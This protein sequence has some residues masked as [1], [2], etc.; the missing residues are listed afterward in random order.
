MKISVIIPVYNVQYYLERCLNSIVNQTYTNLEIILIDDGSTDKSGEICDSYAKID[1]RITVVHKKNEG[2][3]IARNVALDMMTG[4]YISF[5]DSDDFLDLE[6][7]EKMIKLMKDNNVKLAVCSY[8]SFYSE[9]EIQNFNN[10]NTECSI[11]PKIELLKG[12]WVRNPKITNFLWNKL[13]SKELFDNIRFPQ[14]RSVEDLAI[15]YLVIDKCEN[16]VF[17]NEQLY[18]YFDRKDSSS[19]KIPTEFLLEKISIVDKRHKKMYDKYPELGLTLDDYRFRNNVYMFF[20]ISRNCDKEAFLS[21]TLTNEWNN[22]KKYIA[23]NGFINS[24][25]QLDIKYKFLFILLLFN[26]KL[27]YNICSKFLKY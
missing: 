16:A 18:Y 19:K 8:N 9:K 7:Y 23:K 26:K 15:M 10:K 5:V 6:F 12:L 21:D 11:L 1:Q 20:T 2:Q 27:F 13:Y 17:T 22:I 14:K 24:I 25:K 3:S 4:D